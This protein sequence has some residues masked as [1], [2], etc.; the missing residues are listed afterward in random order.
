MFKDVKSF[1]RIFARRWKKQISKYRF[2]LPLFLRLMS[3]A[4]LRA[5]LCSCSLRLALSP[6]A[7]LNLE[8]KLPRDMKQSSIR[9]DLGSSQKNSDSS[10][11][12]SDKLS[13]P[14]FIRDT[15]VEAYW[16][17]SPLFIFTT[18]IKRQNNSSHYLLVVKTLLYN[19]LSGSQVAGKQFLVII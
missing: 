6:T 2:F 19:Q 7:C 11:F 3:S 5:R 16:K 8:Q 15:C 4:S 9:K 14:S 13:I 1:G 10:V 18:L 17:T 12:N